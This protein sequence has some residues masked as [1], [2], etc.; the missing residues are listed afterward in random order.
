VIAGIFADLHR[1]KSVLPGV[2]AISA[3]CSE[4]PPQI[5]RGYL[6]P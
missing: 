5:E 1:T 6:R 2:L 3:G 4:S